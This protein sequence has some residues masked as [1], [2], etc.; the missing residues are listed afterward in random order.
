MAQIFSPRANV[1]SRVVI[2]GFVILV[3][4]AGWV[5][6]AIFWS[7]Y[8]TYVKVPFDQPV[9]FSHQHH[10]AVL[11]LDC[12][13]CHTSVE[14]SA[15]AGMPSTETCMTCH[16]QVWTEAPVL[17]VVRESLA[18]S[19]P[20]HWTRVHQLAD[21]VY[22]DHSIHVR[23]GIGCV[24]CH[25]S[26]DQMPITWKQ[27]TLQMGWCVECHRHPEDALRPVAEVF[28]LNWKPAGND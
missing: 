17:E 1:H 16:S 13:Y 14:K 7:P 19:M 27:Q 2:L 22:F 10:V 25:G 11:G 3:C 28:N 9:P 20:I 18:I 12:R 8:T 24:S 5:T 4:G 21:Y 6:S 23:K 15:F 26:V